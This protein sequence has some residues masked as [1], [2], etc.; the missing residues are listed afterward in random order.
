VSQ[1]IPVKIPPGFFRNGTE[2]EASGRWYDG[3]LVRWLNGRLR[4]W[5]GWTRNDTAQ[6]AFSGVARNIITWRSNAGFRNVAVGT[7]QKLYLS[8]GGSFTDVTPV[9]LVTGRA[10]GISGAGYGASSYGSQSYGTTRTGVTGITL[11]AATWSFDLYGENL[12]C[13]LSSDGVLYQLTPGTGAATAVSGAPTNNVGVLVTDEQYIALLGAGGNL[14]QIKWSDQANPTVW[15][16][17]AT[18][19]AGGLPLATQGTIMCGVKVGRQPL[20]F[21][22][23]DVHALQYLGPPLVYGITRIGDNCG[24]MSAHAVATDTNSAYWMG[25]NGFFIYDG[26]VRPL[27]CDVQDYIFNNINVLQRS[28][29]FVGRNSQY[30][31]LIWF[32]PSVN[33]TEVDSYVVYNYFYKIWYFGSLARTCWADRGA[34]TAPLAVGADGYVY[35]HETGWTNNG[36]SRNSQIFIQSGPYELGNGDRIL[37]ATGLYP[38]ADPSQTATIQFR[39][40]T[41]TAPLGTETDYGPYVAVPNAEGF[42]PLRF[43]GRQAA[44]RVEQINDSEWSY[45]TPR[46]LAGQAGKR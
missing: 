33:S 43:S 24:P 26:I 29:I 20:I 32:Y 23:N 40:K 9:G 1:L 5:G 22:T 4:P 21:T 30:G 7:D 13:V 35:Q 28:K 46:F 44:V 25:L 41:K 17:S 6:V 8:G 42:V 10:D 31:E 11:D 19:T 38:D 36:A 45:G 18:N 39:L 34:F 12:M 37:Y 14:R 27:P 16:A 3:N 15:T 2:Y